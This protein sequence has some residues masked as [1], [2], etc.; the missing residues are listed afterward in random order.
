MDSIGGYFSLELNRQEC[1]F[2][3]SAGVCVNSG[4]NALE[5]ILSS[6]PKIAKLYIPDLTCDSIL[7]PI[8]KLNIP[9]VFYSVNNR[10]EI[11]DRIILED[12]D[13]LVVTN[14]FGIKDRYIQTLASQYVNKLIVDNAQAYFC[15]EFTGIKT[16]YSPRKFVGVPDGGIAVMNNGMDIQKY[17]M[18]CSYDRCSHLLKRYDLGAEAGYS[19]FKDNSRKLS[20]QPIRQMSHLTRSLLSSINFETV[21]KMRIHNFRLLHQTLGQQNHLFIPTMDDFACPMIYPFY[22]HD[23]ILKKHLINHRIFVATYWP[24]VLEWSDEDSTSY[25]LA[26]R[27]IAI[28]VDQRYGENEMNSIIQLIDRF[29]S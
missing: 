1:E 11:S 21:K 24:N 7:E 19:D 8:L 15:P 27:I 23:S 10:L 26:D 3:H 9:Y 16:I 18:D 2:P 4:R 25:Q 14:Y 6:I 5:Y 12:D 28:P 20:N 13:Y 22:T 17:D 29:F